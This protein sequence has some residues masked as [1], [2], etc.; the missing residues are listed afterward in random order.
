M[1]GYDR[2]NSYKSELAVSVIVAWLPRFFAE[3]N[4]LDGLNYK[5]GYT[6]GHPTPIVICEEY[7]GATPNEF[8]VQVRDRVFRE[9]LLHLDG[10][11]LD[12]GH[13]RLTLRIGPW[14][15]P[16]ECSSQ[17]RVTLAHK[18]HSRNG[19]D[20]RSLKRHKSSASI[21]LDDTGNKKLS[22]Q[23]SPQKAIAQWKNRRDDDAPYEKGTAKEKN[24]IILHSKPTG[25]TPESFLVYMNQILKNIN[26][27]DSDDVRILACCEVQDSFRDWVLEMKTKEDADQVMNMSG[28]QVIEGTR[29]YF[30]RHPNY[31][32]VASP[33]CKKEGNSVHLKF[34]RDNTFQNNNA[35]GNTSIEPNDPTNTTS[36]NN[37]KSSPS[38]TRNILDIASRFVY[39]Y[40]KDTLDLPQ[41]TSFMNKYMVDRGFSDHHVIVRTKVCD[42]DRIECSILQL[43][44]D[45]KDAASKLIK[46][47][48]IK[49]QGT[50]LIL[51]NDIEAPTN[52]LSDRSPKI[53]SD[54]DKVSRQVF[55]RVDASIESDSLCQFFDDQLKKYRYNSSSRKYIISCRQL[56]GQSWVLE[57]ATPKIALYLMN[58]N[59]IQFALSKV[60]LTQH[61]K[62]HGS[63]PKF[64]NYADFLECDKNNRKSYEDSRRAAHVSHP[65]TNTST[66]TKATSVVGNISL[67]ENEEITRLKEELEKTK[68]DM[69]LILKSNNVKVKA[70]SASGSIDQPIKLDNPD[71]EGEACS[72]RKFG[73]KE[74][75]ELKI[76]YEK[77]VAELEKSKAKN[78]EKEK[79]LDSAQITCNELKSQVDVVKHGREEIHK[80]WQDQHKEI[81]QQKDIIGSLRSE[82][83]KEI[84]K[85]QIELQDK[86][87]EYQSSTKALADATCMLK[88][89]R[90]SRREMMNIFA[91]EKDAHKKTKKQ[92]KSFLKSTAA[93]V[94]S[95]NDFDA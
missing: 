29:L 53:D 28:K 87:R 45:T 6:S 56:Q 3:S 14:M 10:T 77:V 7:K 88:E 62:Y 41:A 44:I 55:V 23:T 38:S 32:K 4:I 78:K 35:T 85:H 82:Q 27:S 58:F 20:E 2:V 16:G 15:L 60:F 91:N 12:V 47:S 75:D 54:R 34:R 83:L 31:N 30:K 74:Y 67:A 51:K 66:T 76:N 93:K 59:G 9:R 57:M 8:Y 26:M 80:S 5:L 46:L 94:K 61:R 1:S 52:L 69:F 81:N 22:I 86:D 84:A 36:T 71:D 68:K 21:G 79:E 17:K 42:L 24:S 89:E 70:Q 92:L 73:K 18:F 95:E 50:N 19:N 37:K 39:L 48:G 65:K 63:P 72:S 33:A 11:N 25:H 40:H 13:N 49:H 90:E 43:E 64:R